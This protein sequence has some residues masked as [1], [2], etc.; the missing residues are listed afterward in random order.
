MKTALAIALCLIVSGCASNSTSRSF[1]VSGPFGE[2]GFAESRQRI[3]AIDIYENCR[4]RGSDPQ[5]CEAEARRAQMLTCAPESMSTASL[6]LCLRCMSKAV[7]DDAECKQL[8]AAAVSTPD[9]S[10]AIDRGVGAFR[11]DGTADPAT[12]PKIGP[13]PPL[14]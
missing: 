3:Q 13:P 14:K 11:P 9:T 12:H 4:L 8:A 2:V 7:P 5:T 6:G 1:Q 10:I